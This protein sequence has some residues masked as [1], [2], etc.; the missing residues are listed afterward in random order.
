MS[1][2][3]ETEGNG[4]EDDADT[5]DAKGSEMAGGVVVGVSQLVFD[6]FWREW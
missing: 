1:A 3:P 4:E 2:T 5:G 6:E